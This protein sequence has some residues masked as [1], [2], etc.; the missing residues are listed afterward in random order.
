MASY[1]DSIF[2]PR[3]REN[4]SGVEYDADKKTVIYVEDVNKGDDET[5]AIETELGTNPKGVYASVKANLEALWTALVN[6]ISSLIED[7][8]PQLGGDLDVNQHAI[9]DGDGDTKIQLEEAADEDKIRFDT[10]GVERAIISSGGV[11]IGTS[12]PGNLIDVDTKGAATK[13]IRILGGD[14]AQMYCNYYVAANGGMYIKFF[15]DAGT[16]CIV[17]RTYSDSF[18]RGGRLGVG[19]AANTPASQ[20]EVDGGVNIGGTGAIADNNLY[21]TNNCS[22]LSFTDRAASYKG[23]VIEEIKKIERNEKGELDHS[24]LPPSVK[25]QVKTGILD[26]KTGEKTGETVEE[27]IVLG[28][29]IL[30]LTTA[31]QEI[32][33]RI[34]KL[35]NK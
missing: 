16:E 13:G 5:V 12:S 27:G 4:K 23:D 24:T 11:G 9:A 35:E 32:M 7:T 6:K 25:G 29:A 15:D 22:A 33:A 31:V 30:M 20:L 28:N 21:V 1:P 26:E 10:G 3:T 17:F 34:E 18:I 8:T 14:S 2:S 19:D